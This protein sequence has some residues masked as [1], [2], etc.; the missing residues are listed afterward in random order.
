MSF[1]DGS[2]FNV[3]ACVWV[4]YSIQQVHFLYGNRGWLMRS[5]PWVFDMLATAFPQ[6]LS[7]V[8][9]R[10]IDDDSPE[11]IFATLDSFCYFL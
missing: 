3:F 1:I 10:T 8:G 4:V 11:S 5:L 9:R 6:R 2:I 7:G